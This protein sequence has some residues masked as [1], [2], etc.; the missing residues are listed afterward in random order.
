MKG[1]SEPFQFGTM[2]Y[3][4]VELKDFVRAR[5]LVDLYRYVFHGTTEET[6][7][8]HMLNS[9]MQADLR[10]DQFQHVK[11]TWMVLF[12]IARIEA[13]SQDYNEELPHTPQISPKYRFA[14]C[15]GLKIMQEVLFLENDA[16]GIMKLV[17]D[18][19]DAGFEIDSKNWNY[20][21]QV[22]VQLKQF[23]EA[24]ATCEEF[25]MPNWTGWF[26][27][28]VRESIKNQLPLDTRRKGSSPRYLRP[29]ATT[30]YRL[31]QGYMELDQLGPWS[32]EA[33]TQLREIDEEYPQAVRAIK[34]MVRVH[35]SLEYEIFGGMDSP[36]ALE[37]EE[38]GDG[39][40][41]PDGDDAPWNE[42]QQNIDTVPKEN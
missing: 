14:L 15:G 6:L 26:I 28:R 13:R 39:E 38:Y 22:M 2:V 34:S 5:E 40:G 19:R 21:V 17:R 35:S 8:V 1:G 3:M 37:D 27:A 16:A 9:V 4:F 33:R 31:A 12:Q 10:E 11:D 32:A 29:I 18:V 7:P 42:Q 36:F 20:Y 41:Y 30:L 23:R 25:L 24:F